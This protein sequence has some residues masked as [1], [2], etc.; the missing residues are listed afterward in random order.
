MTKKG[1]IS[2][3]LTILSAIG[4]VTTAYLAT[5]NIKKYDN[6]I[7]EAEYEKD[8]NMTDED[9]EQLMKEQNCT[10][11]SE[12]EYLSKKEKGI[13][14]VKSFWPTLASGAITIGCEVAAQILDLQ[15]IGLLTGAV[16]YFASQY[17]RLDSKFEE[18]F[19]EQY[20]AVRESIKQEDMKKANDIYKI[21][22]SYDGKSRYFFPFLDQ[23]IYM[24][25][26]DVVNVQAFISARLA[27]KGICTANEVA[28]YI[29]QDLGYKDVHLTRE[30]LYWELVPFGD[31]EVREDDFPMLVP[32]YDD[33]MDDDGEEVPCIVMSPTIEPEPILKLKNKYA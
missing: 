16:G 5:K 6:K 32:D 7:S 14:F 22:E 4:V 31:R 20:S 1:K 2:V 18:M 15:E 9:F 27:V 10:D 19:P 24:K 30:N 26:N 29:C 11:P 25:P 12:V 33:V 23:I 13:I 8:K 28:D 17:K 21:E 3:A